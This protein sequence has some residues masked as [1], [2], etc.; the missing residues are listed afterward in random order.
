MKAEVIINRFRDKNTKKIYTKDK[1]YEGSASRVAELQE[2]G[3]LGST[4][5]EKT[6]DPLLEGNVEKT[7][8]A[9]TVSLGEEKL[10]A[11]REEE[12]NDKNRKGVLNH[13]DSLLESE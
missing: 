6:S 4:I 13:I 9:I 5:E 1:V 11:L 12:A 7:K 10:R 8:S 2:K 3:W